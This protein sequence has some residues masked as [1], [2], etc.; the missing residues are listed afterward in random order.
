MRQRQRQRIKKSPCTWSKVESNSIYIVDTVLLETFECGFFFICF[1]CHVLDIDK[2]WRM[3]LWAHQIQYSFTSLLW[4]PVSSLL[5]A[6]KWGSVCPSQFLSAQCFGYEYP[7]LYC[8][9]HNVLA[10]SKMRNYY[11]YILCLDECPHLDCYSHSVL[12]I[13]LM[14]NYHYYIL[15]Y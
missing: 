14:R 2:H 13:S 4:T 10:I 15:I 5:Y 7:H 3:H 11:Y 6:Y 8:Y 12:A 9:S 1:L